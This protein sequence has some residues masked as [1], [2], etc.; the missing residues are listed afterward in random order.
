MSMRPELEPAFYPSNEDRQ[1]EVGAVEYTDLGKGYMVYLDP[2]LST[3]SDTAI[4]MRVANSRCV[5]DKGVGQ[6][7]FTERYALEFMWPSGRQPENDDRALKHA[8]RDKIG[9]MASAEA[10]ETTR[11]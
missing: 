10:A 9:R 7:F 3:E 4:A 1:L 8:L 6:V 11:T 5:S 2:S